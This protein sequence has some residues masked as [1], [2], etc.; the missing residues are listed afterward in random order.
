M[1]L[2][3][4]TLTL[5]TRCWW[6]KKSWSNPL[7]ARLSESRFLVMRNA[8]VDE[9]FAQVVVRQ[10]QYEAFMIQ[11]TSTWPN[12]DDDGNIIYA[13]DNSRLGNFRLV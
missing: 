10:N 9:I 13:I 1:A 8:T 4:W 3:T 2:C 12:F 7:T 11:M 6:P 5:S